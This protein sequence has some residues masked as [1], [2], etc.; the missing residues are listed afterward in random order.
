MNKDPFIEY[1]KSS[2]PDKYNKSYAWS[3]AIGLQAV[4]GLE[5]SKYLIDT[6]IKNIEGEIT[7][8]EADALINS[9]YESNPDNSIGNRT[10]E[11]D[12]VSLRIAKILLEPSFTFSP[13][14]YISIHK[15]L[16]IGIYSH[17]GI[18]RDYNMTKKEWI[19]NGD[20][21]SYGTASNL[22][23]TLEYDFK[24]EKN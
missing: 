9:Y 22:M 5:T 7:I 13:C 19:L 23:E 18:I 8:D 11:A 4:D 3:T 1:I 10:E 17:A 2:E 16:F 24:E 20:T 15:K 12:K 6:A 21:V 14:E